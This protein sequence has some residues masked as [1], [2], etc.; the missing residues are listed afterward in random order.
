MREGIIADVML[1]K[2]QTKDP[3]H[4]VE[5]TN[6]KKTADDTTFFCKECNRVW[7]YEFQSARIA[8]KKTSLIYYA[9]FPSYKKNQ[10]VC[11]YCEKKI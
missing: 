6:F 9:N 4:D 8:N 3:K 1:G 11:E 7:E 10:K 2:R 5:S